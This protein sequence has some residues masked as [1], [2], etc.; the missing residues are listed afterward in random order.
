MESQEISDEQLI[1]YLKY[2]KTLS[3]ADG[4][5][6]YDDMIRKFKESLMNITSKLFGKI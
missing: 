6:E 4:K 5:V 2:F 1:N 3:S